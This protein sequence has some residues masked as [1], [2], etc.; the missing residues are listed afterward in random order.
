[1]NA[2]DL[3]SLA[4]STVQTGT[5]L[6]Q[7][8]HRTKAEQLC[9][10]LL[11]EKVDVALLQDDPNNLGYFFSIWERFRR[12]SNMDKIDQWKNAMV[13][14]ITDFHDYDYKDN[15]LSILESL[16]AFDLT[17]LSEFYL[18][19]DQTQD[20]Y[21]LSLFRFFEAKDVP[22]HMVVHSIRRLASQNLITELVQP[23]KTWS[24]L[25]EPAALRFTM[26]DFGRDFIRF[27]SQYSR[28]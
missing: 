21:L 8:F 23:G 11:E 1:M 7:N 20:D 28:D 19:N 4:M 6:Y 2:L 3:V 5:S 16:T 22:E 10:K 12:E 24:T 14:L 26:N 27:V 13:H 17:V 25:T 15:L 18:I 9:E